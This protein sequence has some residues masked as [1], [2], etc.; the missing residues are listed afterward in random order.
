MY[1]AAC[2]FEMKS[3]PHRLGRDKKTGKNISCLPKKEDTSDIN[4]SFFLAS[5]L[6]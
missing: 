1:H 2:P 4:V 5:W 6:R 3:G